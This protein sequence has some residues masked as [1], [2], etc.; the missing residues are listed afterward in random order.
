MTALSPFPML[1]L[2]MER[3]TSTKFIQ[4]FL[5]IL[6]RPL[7]LPGKRTFTPVRSVRE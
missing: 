5:D 7:F 4:P 2:A 3:T 1:R 6:N